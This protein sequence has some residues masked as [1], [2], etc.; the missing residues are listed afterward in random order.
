MAKPPST[1]RQGLRVAQLGM[2]LGV[3]SLICQKFAS[4][5]FL[6]MLFP[7]AEQGIGVS[8]AQLL[9]HHFALL[10]G[11]P[12][13]VSAAALAI[14]VSP[15]RLAAVAQGFVMLLPLTVTCVS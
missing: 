11:T 7:D 4:T 8:I 5:P 3:L 14:E 13:L 10:F 1:F 9:L 6:S 12:L 15:W 2:A